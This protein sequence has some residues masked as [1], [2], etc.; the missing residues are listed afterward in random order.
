MSD[1]FASNS[2]NTSMAGAS[3]PDPPSQPVANQSA[4]SGQT[5]HTRS[6]PDWATIPADADK[7][8]R[9]IYRA[10]SVIVAPGSIV[11][12][13]VPNARVDLNF[14][15]TIA[16]F[17]D[18]DHLED[19]A[20]I[21]QDWSG[22]AQGVYLT[23]NPVLN[24]LL[25]LAA[26]DV[27]RGP[28]GALAQDKHILR[29]T[30]LPFDID[31]CRRENGVLLPPNMSTT[32]EEKAQGLELAERIVDH[33]KREGWPDPILE[34]SG[35]G[36]YLR[37]KVDLPTDDQRLVER[38]I[39]TVSAM[40]SNDRAKVDE[41][42]FN[43]ARVLKIPYTKAC[44]G[45]DREP[46]P[47]RLSKIVRMPDKWEV[48]SLEL[49]ETLA[50]QYDSV[51]RHSLASPKPIKPGAAA[52]V[53][54]T[55][56]EPKLSDSEIR[57]RARRYLQKMDPSIAGQNGHKQ[58]FKV[59]IVLLDKFGIPREV[60]LDLLREYN[61]RPD[62]DPETE[63]QL[64]HKIE[65]AARKVEARGGPS[66][67]LLQPKQQKAAG[68]K[69]QILVDSE[70]LDR[71]FLEARH[72][73]MKAL[74]LYNRRPR[75][76]Q[77]TGALVRLVPGGSKSGH[78]IIEELTAESLN[79][80]P[81][82]AADYGTVVHLK[83]G[84]ETR[85]GY[86][87]ER[88]VKDILHL[89]RWPPKAIPRIHRVV[90]TP[91]FTTTGRL[92]LQPGFDRESGIYLC[93]PEGLSISD[94]PDS[95]TD[96]D[97]QWAKDLIFKD[98][99]WDFPFVKF[100]RYKHVDELTDDAIFYDNANRCHI[101]AYMLQ[102]FL[103]E[104]IDE[105][106]PLYNAEAPTQG[107]GKTRV[108]RYA[109]VPSQGC[110]ASTLS[111]PDTEEEWNKTILTQLRFGAEYV[112]F[113]NLDTRLSSRSFANVLTSTE[114]QGRLLGTNT[115]GV[116]PN[117]V[118]WANSVNNGSFNDDIARRTV[119][120]RLDAG[121]AAPDQRDPNQFK[122][123][124]LSQW[125]R[126]QRSG[127]LRACL[128]LCRRWIAAGMPR[129]TMRF[130]YPQWAGVM[131]GLLQSI[132]MSGFLGNRE[133]ILSDE[134][135]KWVR[136]IQVWL[137]HLESE[138]KELTDP[139]SANELYNLIMEHEGLTVE[140]AGLGRRSEGRPDEKG[141]WVKPT[142]EYRRKRLKDW[143]VGIRDKVYA[144]RVDTSTREYK[145]RVDTGGHHKY[146]LE[147]MAHA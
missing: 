82:E 117:R 116:Y 39:K 79:G 84:E 19:L 144:V 76:F 132:G 63:E 50:A 13:L 4:T 22:K 75:L 11:E 94:V 14:A 70:D 128:I 41:L 112:L 107:T 60:A 55:N 127:L 114:F 64:R 125:A 135:A 44:K 88:L 119:L 122:H 26:N 137:R 134:S 136:L 91:R 115:L 146:W 43:P 85:W 32:E 139:L 37:Y 108:L 21:A 123:C 99:Y 100:P 24:S 16:G 33:L 56:H 69:P 129:N 74:C 15:A 52:A 29:R 1:G 86:P 109:T 18:Y 105:A 57:E 23:V 143:M 90:P 2:G 131:S 30:C 98:L 93:P 103:M 9:L 77:R 133:Q 130:D 120:I 8:A 28:K 3:P 53:A 104:F 20:T 92:L 7:H 67:V 71:G 68:K 138:G 96:A 124:N 121:L 147:E 49:L 113:D 17:F 62:C 6:A 145:V 27:I 42:T 140:F 66:L 58:L 81:I 51:A 31:P 78:T 10:L 118:T 48:V 47:H 61:S 87:N 65:S 35:N 38:C 101:L 73:T 36:Y 5:V 141:N 59:A 72:K 97:V 106:T 142:D 95:P 45:S 54:A 40:F 25:S 83:K 102:P 46:R 12:L 34:D 80:L 110:E 89:K 126:E 111:P